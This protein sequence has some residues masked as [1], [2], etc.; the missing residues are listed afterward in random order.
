MLNLYLNLLKINLEL[1]WCRV[2]KRCFQNASYFWRY[3]K[4][5]VTASSKWYQSGQSLSR[6]NSFS[7]MD[8]NTPGF[9]V[10][11]HLPELTQTHVHWLCRWCHPTISSF[12]TPLSSHLQS[13]PASGSFHM[14]QFFASNG[15]SIGVSASASVLPMNIARLKWYITRLKSKYRLLFIPVPRVVLTVIRV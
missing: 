3:L 11:H 13:F 8:C 15:Q 14:S 10:R 1:K 6:V 4:L 5:M 7:P 2:G 12:V 9:P